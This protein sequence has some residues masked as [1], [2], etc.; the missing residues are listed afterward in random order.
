MAS[1]TL[2][3]SRRS[4]ILAISAATAVAVAG[5]AAVSGLPKLPTRTTAHDAA[6][7][8]QGYQLTAHV[9]NYYRTAGV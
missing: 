4:F 1:K 9:R 2:P 7:G 6:P 8:K 3:V 5:A